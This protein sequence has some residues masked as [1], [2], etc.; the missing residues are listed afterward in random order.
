MYVVQVNE[1]TLA[2]CWTLKQERER[3]KRGGGGARGITQSS[4][5]STIP[6]Y[7]NEVSK[8]IVLH[9]LL[10]SHHRSNGARVHG[11]VGDTV[12]QYFLVCKILSKE[13]IRCDAEH[14]IGSQPS[15]LT[16]FI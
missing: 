1:W 2:S 11:V 14:L 13:Q 9:S 3:K 5:H 8:P 12:L 15:E 10:R 16:I 6:S 7:M 4:T